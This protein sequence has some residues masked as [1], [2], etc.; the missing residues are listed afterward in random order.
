[1]PLP[2]RNDTIGYDSLEAR[3]LPKWLTDQRD[4]LNYYQ[5][6]V[7]EMKDDHSL[8]ASVMATGLLILV[9]LAF[10]TIYFTYKNRK[11]IR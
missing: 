5:P 6:E 2:M 8:T 1:M 10:L 3:P 4:G 9:T 7:L 11:K